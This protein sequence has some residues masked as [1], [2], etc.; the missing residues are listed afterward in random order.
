MIGKVRSWINLAIA[1]SFG[2]AR[3]ILNEAHQDFKDAH[4]ERR[5]TLVVFGFSRGAALAR[6]F[7]SE[8]LSQNADRH[9]SFLGVFDTVAAMNGI[10]RLGEQISSDV[11]FEHGSL[12]PNVDRAVHLL[13]LDEERVMFA[14]TLIN[15]DTEVEKEDRVLEVWLPGVHGDVGGGYWMDGLADVAL[16]L[17]IQQCKNHLDDQVTIDTEIKKIWDLLEEQKEELAEI[18]ADDVVIRPRV[19]GILHPNTGV[20]TAGGLEPRSVHVCE[21]DRPAAGHLPLVH[22]AIKQR[23]DHVAGYRPPAL[24]GVEFRLFGA[25]AGVP[26]NTN[27]IAGLADIPKTERP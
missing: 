13:A 17:M 2:D 4:Y 18:T 7:V 10:H 11:L 21:N 25:P 24:R 22:F 3:R 1:P 6:K 27:G 23:F 5:D 26:A 14:P 12:H 16:E 19:R 20:T 15:R 9:V 8:L